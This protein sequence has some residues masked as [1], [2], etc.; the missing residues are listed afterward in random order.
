MLGFGGSSAALANRSALSGPLQKV[1]ADPYFNPTSFP[2]HFSPLSTLRTRRS[3]AVLGARGS[4]SAAR[5]PRS[6]PGLLG[7]GLGG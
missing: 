4:V 3:G 5:V 6:L 1:S 2:P 7:L